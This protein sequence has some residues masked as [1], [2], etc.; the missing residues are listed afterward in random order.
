MK[1]LL[2]L[3]VTC[4]FVLVVAIFFIPQKTFAST[5]INSDITSDAVWDASNNPYVISGSINIATGTTLTIN[6]GVIVKFSRT[7]SLNISGSISALGD[8][9]NKIYF[10]SINNDAVGGVVDGSDDIPFKGENLDITLESGSSGD[11]ENCEFSYF[12]TGLEAY[13]DNLKVINS[14]FDNNWLGLDAS[15]S[16]N[17]DLEN[18]IFANN[19]YP[20]FV[21]LDTNFEHNNNSYSNNE[22]FDAIGINYPFDNSSAKL[23][24]SNGDGNYA[25]VVAIG[26]NSNQTLSIDPGVT[27]V[28]NNE[29]SNMDF[30][31][32]GN[33]VMS[34]TADLPIVVH[35]IN[36]LISGDS[37]KINYVNFYDSVLYPKLVNYVEVKNSN[38]NCGTS[39]CI[40]FLDDKNVS[41]SNINIVSTSVQP[42]FISD[43]RIVAPSDAVSNLDNVTINGGY[44]G[45]DISRGTN[46]NASHIAISGAYYAGI[47]VADNAIFNLSDSIIKNN[48]I[49]IDILQGSFE[50]FVPIFTQN[51]NQLSFKRVSVV[52]NK[53]G[54]SIDTLYSTDNPPYNLKNIWWGDASG[55]YNST[56]NSTGLGDEILDSRINFIPWLKI[57]PSLPQKTPVLIVPGVLGTEISKQNDDGSLTKLWLDI[58]HNLTDLTDNFMDPLQFNDDL[59]PSDTSLVLG[60]VIKKIETS[61]GFTIFD[62]SDGLINEFKNVGYEE[63]QDVFTFPYDWRYGVNEDTVNSLKQKISDILD[64]TGA[65]KVDVVAHSTGGLIVKKYV[66]ENPTSNNIDKAVFVG[67]PNTGSPKAIKTLLQ[68]D[69]FGNYFLSDSEMQKIARNLPVVYDLAPSAQYYNT[70][71]SFVHRMIQSGF[72]ISSSTDLTFDDMDSFLINDHNFNSQAWNNSKNL[73]TSDFDNYDM[74]NAGVDI[75]AIDGCKGGTIG[76]VNELQSKDI[77][78]NNLYKY[79]APQEVPGDGTVPLESATNL[80]INDSNKFYALSGDHG[81]MLS[82]DGIRQQIVNITTSTSNVSIIK[83]N[84]ITQDIS[85][86]GL[87]GHAISIY[88][89]LSIDITDANGNHSGLSSDGVSIENNILNA[90]YEIMDDHKFVYLP[91]DDGQQYII[92]IAGTGNGVFTLT[93]TT[94]D[95]NQEI[96]MQ[97]FSKIPVT[98]SSTGIVQIASTTSLSINSISDNNPQIILPVT[99][100]NINDIENFD[101][102]VFDQSPTYINSNVN[103]S[104][105]TT[106]ISH[107]GGYGPPDISEPEVAT[108]ENI[109]AT[110]GVM[111]SSSTT[112]PV[113]LEKNDSVKRDI[114][115]NKNDTI[116]QEVS[117]KS[118]IATTNSVLIQASAS[119]SGASSNK[120]II[121]GSII[122]FGLLYIISK[123][124]VK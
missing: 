29:H 20:L 104:T 71:G 115:Y 87:N 103:T 15:Y 75:Y 35:N 124:I 91:Y 114:V 121:F 19:T 66:M 8:P 32:G 33:F 92:K 52:G 10:T 81:N 25:L 28:K 37:S 22:A 80:P 93:D 2:R 70:K 58:A 95:N 13:S 122:G 60:D 31:I 42:D 77:F 85:K 7:S 14:S 69:N 99:V 44:V 117:Q 9:A 57:D 84:V 112:V 47:I 3:V 89:P 96:Q 83:P 67:V 59:T 50:S 105:Q 65:D 6:P 113:F 82:V 123:K 30:S 97:V 26:V 36:F 23:T 61:L 68:G 12:S 102:E 109:I 17:L 53:T 27:F 18:S 116:K 120:N 107:G 94:I 108:S 56:T 11:F 39:G 90:D 1:V 62:Y 46:V 72:F 76:K 24:Y 110:S 55:P 5:I 54:A 118:V 74:R 100:S 16:K 86:C 49:G 48:S 45:L 78:G 119:Q 64:E 111:V 43:L 101:P 106:N 40:F 4:I 41:V 38:F 34:G 51:T 63:N 73:H 79:L 88:S 98:S 21:S